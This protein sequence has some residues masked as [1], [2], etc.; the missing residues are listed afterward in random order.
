VLRG[1][2]HLRGHGARRGDVIKER[3]DVPGAGTEWSEIVGC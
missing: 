1:V 3:I 2:G